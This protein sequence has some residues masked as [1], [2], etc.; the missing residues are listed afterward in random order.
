VYQGDEEWLALITRPDGTHDEVEFMAPSDSGRDFLEDE[1][2]EFWL[3]QLAEDG[4]PY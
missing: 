1:A 2:R 4:A 3:E